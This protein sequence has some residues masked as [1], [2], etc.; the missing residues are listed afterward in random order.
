MSRSQ[1]SSSTM[2][3][4]GPLMF[5][6]DRDGPPKDAD[7]EQGEGEDVITL[8]ASAICADDW[9]STGTSRGRGIV[10]SATVL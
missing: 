7:L 10:T 3:P 4:A 1:P 5:E 8:V 6:N 2:K 9:D